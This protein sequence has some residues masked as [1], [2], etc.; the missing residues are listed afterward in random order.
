MKL[1]KYKRLIGCL[2]LTTIMIVAEIVQAPRI[3]AATDTI[4]T[5]PM[6]TPNKMDET[7]R[8]LLE[9][10][11]SAQELDHEI[12]RVGAKEQAARK[13]HN[14]L[15]QELVVQQQQLYAARTQSDRVLVAYYT[16]ERDQL[17]LALLS[18]GSL[19]GMLTFY[20]YY[21]MIIDHD[22]RIMNSY[23]Q[24]YNQMLDKQQQLARTSSE[25]QQIGTNL[26]QQK[27]RVALLRQQI[28][29]GIASSSNPATMRQLIQELNTYWENI[30]LYEVRG[31]FEILAQSMN[32]FPSFLKSEPDAIRIHGRSYTITISEQQLNQFLHQQGRLPDSFQF[33]FNEQGI[34]VNGQEGNLKLDIAGHYEVEQQPQNAIRFQVDRLIFN[35]LELPNTTRQQLENQ[36][37][38]GFYPGQIISYLK[39]KHVQMSN[40]QMQIELELSL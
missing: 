11:L 1:F 6:P 14:Q 39:A 36:F 17:W 23:Q 34:V 38:L 22:H 2:L 37:D 9:H 33:H 15:Q 30:G 12:A 24:Q 18:T 32:Q 26:K 3:S 10:S 19:S 7:T 25:L 29:S 16:G 4:S 21:Q 28:D 8:Q 31:Y 5:Q 27:E 13:Q 20:E 40:G 35:G